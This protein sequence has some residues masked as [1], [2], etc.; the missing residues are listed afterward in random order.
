MMRE[1]ER[2]REREKEE[3]RK[4]GREGGVYLPASATVATLVTSH[5][6]L[7]YNLATVGG[8]ILE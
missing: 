5:V 3:G 8:Y 4:K 1:R 7:V 6:Q 2:E